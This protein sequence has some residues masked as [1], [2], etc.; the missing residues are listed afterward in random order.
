MLGDKILVARWNGALLA[1]GRNGNSALFLRMRD[2]LT[3]TFIDLGLEAYRIK[4][5]EP[6][7]LQSPDFRTLAVGD[8]MCKEPGKIAYW[9][10]EQMPEQLTIDASGLEDANLEESLRQVVTSDF[11]EEMKSLVTI[12]PGKRV[13]MSMTFAVERYK[14]FLKRV[15]REEGKFQKRPEVI[16]TCENTLTRIRERE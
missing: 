15:I 6:L 3:G 5:I 16:S 1:N 14:P 10:V 2:P 13:N 7:W 12:V 4:V 11:T 8:E 9:Q